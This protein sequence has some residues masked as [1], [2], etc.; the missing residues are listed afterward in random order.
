MQRPLR[1]VQV[2][3]ALQLKTARN[4]AKCLPEVPSDIAQAAS[5]ICMMLTD[6][7]KYLGT[8]LPTVDDGFD[9]YM[10]QTGLASAVYPAGEFTEFG[11]K[12]FSM[13][14]SA[15]AEAMEVWS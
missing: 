2:M 4:L 11:V 9:V 1:Y 14:A 15:W 5:G 12:L 13:F 6:E 10:S 8:A 3:E 7:R